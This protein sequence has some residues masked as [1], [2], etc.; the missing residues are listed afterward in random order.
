MYKCVGTIGDAL[1]PLSNSHSYTYE[2]FNIT[3]HGCH[4]A[5]DHHPCCCLVPQPDHEEPPLLW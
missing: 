2:P 4:S 5:D 1:K 3:H